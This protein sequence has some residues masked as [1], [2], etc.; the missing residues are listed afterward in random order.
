VT[1]HQNDEA[2]GRYQQGSIRALPSRPAWVIG[3]ECVA[4]CDIAGYHMPV[5]TTVFVNPWVIHRDARF[6]DR[7]DAFCPERSLDDARS[8]LPRYAYLPFGVGPRLCIG[9]G[10]AMTEATMLLAALARRFRASLNGA[11]SIAPFLTIT[12]RPAVPMPMTLN[13]R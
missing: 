9:R 11:Q 4:P 3:R 5:G 7:P 8:R 1:S 12:L 10:F 13:A 2:A 6:Y